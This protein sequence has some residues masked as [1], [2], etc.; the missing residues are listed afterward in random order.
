[1]QN[2]YPEIHIWLYTLWSQTNIPGLWR[3]AGAP[4]WHYSETAIDNWLLKL[5]DIY[6]APATKYAPVVSNHCTGLHRI[7]LLSGS[8]TVLD[9]T[10][11]CFREAQYLPTDR[12]ARVSRESSFF[13][14]VDVVEFRHCL[15]L[16]G[17]AK[18]EDYVEVAGAELLMDYIGN[19]VWG[20]WI[21]YMIYSIALSDLACWLSWCCQYM[22]S[23]ISS[24]SYPSSKM[25]NM[26][27][28]LKRMLSLGDIREATHTNERP[29]HGRRRI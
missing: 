21:N 5:L 4:D 2:S 18:D 26:T 20:C 12:T 14:T 1:M 25:T 11:R 6:I 8:P 7:Q 15:R 29:R 24:S 3:R 16:K 27:N 22:Y 28:L 13:I 19:T 10:C 23:N 9:I 17:D